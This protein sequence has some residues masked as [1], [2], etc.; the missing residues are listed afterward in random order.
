MLRRHTSGTQQRA[1]PQRFEHQPCRQYMLQLRRTLP[2]L[3]SSPRLAFIA[4]LDLPSRPVPV[5]RCRRAQVAPFTWLHDRFAATVAAPCASWTPPPGSRRN[6]RPSAP[7]RPMCSPVANPAVTMA[8][9][10]QRRDGNVAWPATMA[11]RLAIGC[12]ALSR[13]THAPQTGCMQHSPL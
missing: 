12:H 6:K 13:N 1:I 3:G 5:I 8:R 10:I 4:L 2:A 7:H 9:N 11:S